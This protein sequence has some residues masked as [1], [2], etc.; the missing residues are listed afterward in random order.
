M[1]TNNEN[2][3]ATV[4]ESLTVGAEKA[5]ARAKTATTWWARALWLLAGA[6]M[7]LASMWLSS[8]TVS[9]SIGADGSQLY[10]HTIVVPVELYK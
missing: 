10:E 1:S 5:V 7:A 6:A 8:C 9:W 3:K 4:K 2:K